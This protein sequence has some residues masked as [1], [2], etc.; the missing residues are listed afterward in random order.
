MKKSLIAVMA[1]VLSLVLTITTI[2]NCNVIAEEIDIA[3]EYEDEEL[4][5]ENFENQDLEEYADY[6]VD[7]EYV[8]DFMDDSNEDEN[9]NIV[10]FELNNLTNAQVEQISDDSIKSLPKNAEPGTEVKVLICYDI[11]KMYYEYK[12]ANYLYNT[13]NDYSKDFNAAAG[14][15]G[16]VISLLPIGKMTE[17]PKDAQ[18]IYNSALVGKDLVSSKDS[19]DVC[20][21]VIGCVP[22]LGPIYSIIKYCNDLSIKKSL[23]KLK[24]RKNE[25]ESK[26][27]TLNESTKI[28]YKKYVRRYRR[29]ILEYKKKI[30][31]ISRIKNERK[32]K[33]EL[34]KVKRKYH[35]ILKK[36]HSVS[37]YYVETTYVY[38]KGGQIYRPEGWY[39]KNKIRYVEGKK[40]KTNYNLFEDYRKYCQ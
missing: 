32:K 1:L 10:K 4:S 16:N 15:L 5:N 8:K 6:E 23:P 34:R 30:K 38:M 27:S 29:K 35:S 11:G 19:A 14:L 22:Y 26:Y 7:E 24:K 9:I 12:N 18:I 40:N 21:V 17:M 25:L 39:A 33:R 2:P 36:K 37:T 31:G 13:L 3:S 28:A 20:N